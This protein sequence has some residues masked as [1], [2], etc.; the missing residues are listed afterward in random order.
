MKV[1]SYSGQEREIQTLG[2]AP[3]SSANGAQAIAQC[4]ALG[5]G[6][7]PNLSRRNCGL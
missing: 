6:W 5:F 4:E 3:H 7:T 1:G 2:T